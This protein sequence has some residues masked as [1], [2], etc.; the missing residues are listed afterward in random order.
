LYFGCDDQDDSDESDSDGYDDDD[1]RNDDSDEYNDDDV[2]AVSSIIF[3]DVIYI[4]FQF[5][6]D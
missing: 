5:F 4:S 2:I 1:D 6:N 3:H